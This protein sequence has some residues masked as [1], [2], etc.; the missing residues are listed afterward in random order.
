MEG[1]ITTIEDDFEVPSEDIIVSDS[2]VR[3]KSSK[4]KGSIEDNDLI[5]PDFS[6]YIDGV[7][8]Y[9]DFDN[10]WDFKAAK[11]GLKDK[12][13]IPSKTLDEIIENKRK[14]IEK[15][16]L[17]NLDEILI[18][19]QIVNKK[20]S[21][22]IKDLNEINKDNE[23]KVI[24]NNVTNGKDNDFN[25]ED[26][27]SENESDQ[28]SIDSND[29]DLDFDG[30]GAG[31]REYISEDD[32]SDNS[33]SKT[34]QEQGESDNDENDNK[35]YDRN[36]NENDNKNYDR[37]GNE[38]DTVSSDSEE[39]NEYEKQ[40]K[41]EYF[42]DKSEII[43]SESFQ[44]MN[45]SRPILKG[46]S[47]LGY[48]QPTPIQM[49]TIPV[50]LTGKDICGGA[51]TGSGKTVAFLVPIM[52]RLLYRP[53]QTPT[54]RV[55]ILAPTRELAIQCHNVSTKLACFTDIVISL[56]VGGLS[57]KKQEIE[58]RTRPD[59]VIAT[60]GRLIDHIR[61]SPS[62]TL[63]KIEI[64]IIDEADRMLEDGFADE[65]NEIV[66]NCPK[67]RQTMLFSATMTDNIDELIRLSLNRPIKLMVDPAKTT[68][69]QLTQ[70]FVRV[71]E[72]REDDRAAI[73]LVLCKQIFH[74]RVIIFFRSKAIAHEMKIIFGLFGLKAAELH[75]NLSQEQR[76]E[77]LETFKDGE[78]DF[79]LA[80]DLASRGL[81]IKG[82]ET[83]INYNMPQ[84][85]EHYIHRVGRT[86]R[87]GRKGRSVTLTGEADRKILKSVVKHTP[88]DQVKRRTIDPNM[89]TEFRDK[90]DKLKD[91]IKE[92]S[93][94]E[95]EEKA[96]RQAEMELQ[97]NQNLLT[98]EKEIYNRPARTWFQSEQK[99]KQSRNIATEQYNDKFG[100]PELMKKRKRERE[101]LEESTKSKQKRSKYAGMS[102][103]KR[104]SIQMKD[105]STNKS[106]TMKV[107]KSAKKAQRP[108][109]ILKVSK[110][111]SKG[112]PKKV[113][114][115]RKS[116]G[117]KIFEMDMTD[118]SKKKSFSI[119][120]KVV[121]TKKSKKES[122]G[123]SNKK[124]NIL[125]VKNG[126]IKKKMKMK[127]HKGN[128]QKRWCLITEVIIDWLTRP[129]YT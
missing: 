17:S 34:E 73:L 100:S 90:L 31:T 85:Y 12:S 54:V 103:K 14:D 114:S 107:I 61:N 95:K 10:G 8:S 88:Q 44:M 93:Q 11:A 74:H 82:I 92:I 75:G 108:E 101:D 53:K 96:I 125:S 66:K 18:N 128:G 98:H 102:R 48:T 126:G 4:N 57:L 22:P 32:D 47:K 6:F 28:I 117:N 35:N 39:E 3:K 38:N 105:D 60:P 120:P 56:C 59:I 81:D 20:K 16:K 115:S 123:M 89:L 36:G 33:L 122:E 94:E 91:Q 70:E 97:K 69:A 76:L 64:L 110:E 78:V 118:S 84:S 80:T 112:L 127:P 116:V 40:R 72:H 124:K 77:A 68:S 106:E 15:N 13:T 104:R 5:N 26:E 50:A 19:G 1:F 87:A 25:K 37:N 42:A 55:L 113:N 109:K 62:F 52:E 49:Q 41:K 45:L 121:S 30:F 99:K 65:L 111:S 86:A 43:K 51:I 29:E 21:K 63:D 58:L 83:V 2:K 24:N 129:G 23:V 7:S 67:S 79:L 71:R 27:S 9:I 119:T 46:L